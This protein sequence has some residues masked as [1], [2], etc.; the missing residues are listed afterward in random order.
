MELIQYEMSEKQLT[1]TQI[2]QAIK[3]GLKQAYSQT[4]NP[5][6]TKVETFLKQA[7]ITQLNRKYE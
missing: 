3:D 1:Q 6:I 4:S 2:E 7:I 5:C